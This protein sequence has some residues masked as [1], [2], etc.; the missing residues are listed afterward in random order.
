MEFKSI[1]EQAWY[2]FADHLDREDVMSLLKLFYIT[3]CSHFRESSTNNY[4]GLQW[5]LHVCQWWQTYMEYFEK[6]ALG[7]VTH[8]IHN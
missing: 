2:E 1:V 3:V 8:F 5:V 6:R 7:R 4:M